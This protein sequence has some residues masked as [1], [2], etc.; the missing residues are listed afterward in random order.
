MCALVC[1]GKAFNFHHCKLFEAVV[2]GIRWRCGHAM[3]NVTMVTGT[4]AYKYLNSFPSKN[5]FKAKLLSRMHVS[6]VR[7]ALKRCYEAEKARNGHLNK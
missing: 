4:A 7:M 2:H 3:S 5:C 6:L 1:P